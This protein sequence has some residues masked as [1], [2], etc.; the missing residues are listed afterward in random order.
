MIFVAWIAME[1]PYTV[2]TVSVRCDKMP[3]SGLSS[4]RPFQTDFASERTLLGLRL[5]E[6]GSTWIIDAI[7]IEALGV[8]HIEV[9]GSRTGPRLGPVIVPKAEVSTMLE[10]RQRL[11]VDRPLRGDK[12]PAV[13]RAQTAVTYH[14]EPPVVSDVELFILCLWDPVVAP[15]VKR[16][17]FFGRR[18]SSGAKGPNAALPPTHPSDDLGV[19]P[20]KLH[21][22]EDRVVVSALEGDDELYPVSFAAPEPIPAFRDFLPSAAPH[23]VTSAP[24]Y[25]AVPGPSPPVPAFGSHDAKPSHHP[26]PG[27]SPSA[28]A[29]PTVVGKPLA[30]V[31][32]C[33]S[34]Y[35]NPLRGQI[36][37]KAIALGA[38]VAADWDS[39]CTHLVCAV[40][41]TPKHLEVVKSGHGIVVTKQWIDDCD[42]CKSRLKE[43]GYSLTAAAPK[44]LVL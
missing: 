29:A 2:T 26:A 39:S 30:G 14:A 15:Y 31:V 42:M 10:H 34:G 6:S 32:M 12:P 41:N 7:D 1:I 21:T 11:L 3:A 24:P 20:T 38:K 43:D 36:R 35:Q 17:T 5:A 28:I 16:L 25:H 4:G 40:A 27:P 23:F 8:S 44:F 18:V 37:D 13:L 9:R 33:L 19:K 22:A